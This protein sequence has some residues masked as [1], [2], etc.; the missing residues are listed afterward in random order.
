ML[1]I[2]FGGTSLGKRE[3]LEKIPN[4]LNDIRDKGTVIVVSAISDRNKKEGITSKLIS[5]V[6]KGGEEA[7][8]LLNE[9]EKF[10]IDFIKKIINCM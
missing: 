8:K 2:K 1:V 6:N 4:I 9:V 7:K 10:H 3:R 5:A